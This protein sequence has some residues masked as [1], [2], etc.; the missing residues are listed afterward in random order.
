LKP[1]VVL[2]ILGPTAV[3]YATRSTSSLTLAISG[4]SGRFIT[5]SVPLGTLLRSVFWLPCDPTLGDERATSSF[6]GEPPHRVARVRVETE[7][8]VEEPVH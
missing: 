1:T 2:V 6:A 5:A 3:D 7:T 4:S 8:D